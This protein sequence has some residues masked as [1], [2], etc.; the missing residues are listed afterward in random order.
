M[1]ANNTIHLTVLSDDFGMCPAVN[2]GIAR[3]FTQGVLTDTNLMAPCP[4]FDEAVQLAKTHKIPVGI[5]TTFTAEWDYWRWKPL[6]ELKSMVRTD[7]TFH[8]TILDAWKNANAQ[9]AEAE[10]E[11]QWARIEAAGLSITHACEHM[12]AE[13]TLANLLSHLLRVKKVPYRNFSL[14]GDAHQIP[15]YYWDSVFASSEVGTDIVTR[16]AKLK[17][18]LFSLRPGYHIWAAH[19]AVDHPS[20]EKL[21]SPTHP[22]VN[23]T[24]LYRVL[25]QALIEDPEV[26]EWIDR[27][28][29]QLTPMS[30]CLSKGF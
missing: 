27:Q 1:S 13:K 7:G 29:I 10:F 2:E 23:W 28:G 16:K 9:E 17:E 24:R 11:A 26:G 19:C 15:H 3:A 8:K 20:L 4:S 21:T 5:H 25:D 22:G 18:W 6:T 14:N 12:G 30:Q